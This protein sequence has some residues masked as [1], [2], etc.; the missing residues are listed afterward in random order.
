MTY[1]PTD[2]CDDTASLA[3]L[4]QWVTF[5]DA[6]TLAGVAFRSG[7]ALAV[8]DNVITDPAHSVP[9]KLLGKKLALK[10]AVATSKLEGRLARESALRDAFHL[11]VRGDARGPDGDLLAFWR[12]ASEVR[13]TDQGLSAVEN[14]AGSHGAALK[15]WL[16]AGDQIAREEGP[17]AG[18]GSVLRAVLQADDR[19]ERI[20]CLL[21]DVVLAR[22]LNWTS[23]LPVSAQGLSKTMLRDLVAGEEGA[24]LSVQAGLLASINDALHLARDLARRAALLGAVAPKLRAKGSQA[25]VA[26]FLSEEAVSPATMLSPVIQGTAIAMTDR[27]ARRFCDRLVDLGVA[28]ELSGRTSFRLYGIAP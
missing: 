22:A 12:E 2:L 18:C 8:L 14:L 26:L 7:A 11:S 6:Q 1:Q 27:A 25:A 5:R 17:L 10:A 19:A 20:A 3:K 24:D 28:Q 9:L 4:P 23:V 13:A 21:A 15:G 16:D